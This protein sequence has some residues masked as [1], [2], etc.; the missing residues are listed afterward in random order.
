MEEYK[1][2]KNRESL[3]KKIVKV[4]FAL[5]LYQI[6]SETLITPSVA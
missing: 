1:E 6:Q 2:K 4:L 5:L 3:A